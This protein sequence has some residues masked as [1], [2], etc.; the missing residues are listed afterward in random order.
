MRVDP[1]QSSFLFV[2]SLP[3]NGY[4]LRT[5]S[6]EKEEDDDFVARNK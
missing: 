1:K 2:L 6:A 3:Q 4:Y 5:R